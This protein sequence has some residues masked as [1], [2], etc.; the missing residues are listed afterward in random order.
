MMIWTDIFHSYRSEKETV[1]EGDAAQEKEV[2]YPEPGPVSYMC[3]DFAKD[4]VNLG[5]VV[6]DT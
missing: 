1:G 6:C 5:A 4:Q 2:F 3:I